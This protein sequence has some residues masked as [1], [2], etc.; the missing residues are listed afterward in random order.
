MIFLNIIIF[1]Q[2]E[3]MA[4][5]NNNDEDYSSDESNYD[6]TGGYS[7][8]LLNKDMEAVSYTHL[9]LPTICSV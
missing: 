9:T 7:F 2:S 4:A 8:S 5:Y 1:E 6:S 3:S